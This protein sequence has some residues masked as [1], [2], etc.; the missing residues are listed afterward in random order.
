MLSN[1]EKELVQRGCCFI[2]EKLVLIIGWMIFQRIFAV[3]C[4]KVSGILLSNWRYIFM[5]GWN[6]GPLL[7]FLR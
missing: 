2:E 6:S 4:V 7:T 1:Q 5:Y 3:E